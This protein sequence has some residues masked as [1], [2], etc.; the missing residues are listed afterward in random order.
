M[1]KS[2]FPDIFLKVGSITS[3]TMRTIWKYWVVSVALCSGKD[4]SRGMKQCPKMLQ[5]ITK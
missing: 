1:T 3:Q 5:W 2:N 4:K